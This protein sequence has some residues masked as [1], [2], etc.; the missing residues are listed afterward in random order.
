[1]NEKLSALLDA[2]R[3]AAAQATD[4]ASTAAYL[5][6]KKTESTLQG[7]RRSAQINEQY[8][9]IDEE[10]RNLGMMLYATH[11]GDPTDSDDLLQKLEEIDKLREELDRME[12]EAGKG[13]APCSVCGAAPREGDTFCRE[14]GAKL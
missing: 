11:T 14:C 2:A 12:K 9:R 6:E 13:P 3:K 10:L 8:T 4:T 5:V 7:M 1:M